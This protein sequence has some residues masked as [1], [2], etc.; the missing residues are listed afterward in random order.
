MA[1]LITGNRPS[2]TLDFFS[3]IPYKEKIKQFKKEIDGQTQIL[4]SLVEKREVQE[5]KL[6][7]L[8]NKKHEL[9]LKIE[10]LEAKSVLAANNL[11]DEITKRT[12]Y[13]VSIKQETHKEYT[14]LSLTKQDVQS[15]TDKVSKLSLLVRELEE[16]ILKN[17]E[18]RGQYLQSKTD[19]GEIQKEKVAVVSEVE[20][21]KAEIIAQREDLQK[22]KE[23]MTELFS[24]LS[25]YMYQVSRAT[26][27]LNRKLKEKG[28]PV[29][30]EIPSEQI[31]KIKF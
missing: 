3:G 5:Q 20:K 10:E 4:Q 15:L 13:I 22:S 11:E 31:T 7:L 16:F 2:S 14:I 9:S 26:V 25:Q 12:D 1:R 28:V 6:E 30:Y 29:E 17:C 23:S 27:F 18:A 19:L 8:V 21:E 24:R